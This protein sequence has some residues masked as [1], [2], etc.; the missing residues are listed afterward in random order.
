VKVNSVHSLSYAMFVL[1]EYEQ[2]KTESTYH[3]IVINH[4]ICRFVWH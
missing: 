1:R 4:Y 3:W 2:L